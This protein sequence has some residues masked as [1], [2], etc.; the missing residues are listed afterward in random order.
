VGTSFSF[1]FPSPFGTA[2][3]FVPPGGAGGSSLASLNPTAVAGSKL[4]TGDRLLDPVTRDYV[5][6]ANGEWAE[7]GDART[8]MML[9]LEIEL[10]LSAYTPEDGTSVASLIRDGEPVTP[11]MLQADIARAAGL[12]VI[13]GLIGNLNVT[14]RDRDGAELVD[15]TGRLVVE[16]DYTDLTTGSAINQAF[17]PR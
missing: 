13:S 9:M 6:T 2:F 12:L 15:E 17:N 3:S 4:G 1:P 16:L 8:A 14:V 10:G 11:E 7:T 5:R